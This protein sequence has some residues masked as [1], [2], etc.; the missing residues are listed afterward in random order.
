[1]KKLSFVRFGVLALLTAACSGG[2]S[3]ADGQSGLRRSDSRDRSDEDRKEADGS[4]GASVDDEL[5]VADGDDAATAATDD[6]GGDG[7]THVADPHVSDGANDEE[8]AETDAAN[9]EEAPQ[10]PGEQV[11]DATQNG[12]LECSEADAQ[13]RAPYDAWKAQPNALG[14]LAGK[15]F[16]GYVEGGPD[17]ALSVDGDG[18]AVLAVGEAA[19]PPEADKGYLC[20]DELDDAFQCGRRYNAPPVEGAT[21]ELHGASLEG[22][23]LVA[24]VQLN[25][26]YDAWCSMQA[27]VEADV[28]YYDTLGLAGFSMPGAPLSEGATPACELGTDPVDCGWLDLSLYSPCRCTSSECFAA[29][30]D[31]TN[32]SIDARYDASNGEITGTFIDGERARSSVYLAEVTA[33]GEVSA[34]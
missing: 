2:G 14:E 4:D 18:N 9:D 1:M 19:P 15:T 3:V 29:I 33:E 31:D 12:A 20:G 16:A 8:P 30:Y 13:Y 24:P 25:S 6:E 26:P 28:C 34:E 32:V 11:G 5:A 10:A 22:G 23:R 7:S 17:L 27:P 21:Y